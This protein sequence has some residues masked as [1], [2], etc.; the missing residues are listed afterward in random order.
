M[1]AHW[2]CSVNSARK[3]KWAVE[4]SSLARCTHLRGDWQRA[5]ALVGC[6]VQIKSL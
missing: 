5:D 3:F 2:A 1:R 6:T 4:I